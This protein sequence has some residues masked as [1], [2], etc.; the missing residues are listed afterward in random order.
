MHYVP[1][2]HVLHLQQQRSL[3][4][5]LQKALE[6]TP[7]RAART[8]SQLPGRCT[9]ADRR[10]TGAITSLS[11]DGCLFRT[12]NRMSPNT[13]LNLVFPLPRGQMISTRARVIEKR[14]DEVGLVFESIPIS[15][16]N[17]VSEFV[18][19]RLATL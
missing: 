17:A 10:W 6:D 1:T 16:Q 14:G 8:P 18:E 7:R 15:V 11:K 3:Y 12:N 4:P 5:L 9:F 2:T 13:E 19:G